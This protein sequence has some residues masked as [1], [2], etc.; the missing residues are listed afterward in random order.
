MAIGDKLVNLDALKAVH[1]ADAADVADLK[2]AVTG[3]TTA[4][5]SDAG[6]SLIAKTVSGGK[7]TEWEF[8]EAVTLDDTLT[9]AGEA[10]D[11]KAAGDALD[12]K[13]PVIIDSTSQSESH[14]GLAGVKSITFHGN[15]YAFSTAR[16]A[17]KKNLLPLVTKTW[18]ADSDRLSLQA[19]GHF[20]TYNG[21]PTAKGNSFVFDSALETPL[22]AGNYKVLVELSSTTA[23]NGTFYLSVFYESAPTTR[24][25]AVS[26]NI[27]SSR[28]NVF[29]FTATDKIVK[30]GYKTPY[31]K[32]EVYSNF[33]V[34]YGLYD[35]SATIVDTELT[36][37]SDGTQT[38][39]DTS[40]YDL[41][42]IDTMQHESV[43][44]Y[45]ADTKTYVDEHTPDII[46][47]WNDNIYALPEDFGAVG[48][49]TTDDTTALENCI[50]YSASS[51]KPVRGFRKYKAT[52]TLLINTRYQDVFLR[53]LVYTGNDAA[54]QLSERNI[55]FEF[56]VIES[57]GIGIL[58]QRYSTQACQYH[59]VTGNR[60]SSVGDC[61]K[62]TGNTY[63]ST[64]N[65]RQLASSAGNCINFD[66]SVI[67]GNISEYT[68]RDVTFSCPAGWAGKNLFG[69]KLYGCTVEGDVLNGYLNPINCSFFGCRHREFIDCIAKRLFD[70]DPT[71]TNGPLIKY[72]VNP[73]YHGS[74]GLKYITAD[75]IPWCSIDVSEIQNYTELPQ[76]ESND[77]DPNWLWLAYNG[78]DVGVA[79]R[80][81]ETGIYAN[82]AERVY[83]IG[84]H[85]VFEPGC[86]FIYTF[87]KATY[88]M[89]LFES[90]TDADIL[91]AYQQGGWGTDFVTGYSHTDYY[92]N[93][94]F[95][96]VGYSDLT[97]TQKDGN[98]ATL[99]DKLG[100]V[101]F[102]GTNEGNGVWHF[103]CKV[104]RSKHGRCSGYRENGWWCY[105]G[106]NETWEITKI[107]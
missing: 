70:N 10:A 29:D 9:Q 95:G 102:D 49:G 90:N 18:T 37:A 59:V 73:T 12:G 103:K 87:D 75:A 30:I 74:H 22:P 83:F 104:D 69:T 56:D 48:D 8:G 89:T 43:V 65:I 54:I 4:T 84:Y 107:G 72:T 93:A 44:A 76:H 91:A 62:V 106:T 82:Y 81:I 97:L 63:Y 98:T 100:N 19:I 105:D 99:Y 47:F 45:V 101:L 21:T 32:D 36:V 51:G 53:Y 94:S 92:M 27:G 38:Y 64:V 2:S 25:Q 34:W 3:M 52:S 1:D 31:A 67:T 11:A 24:V 55:K 80:G 78:Q 79:I 17:N 61:I 42:V 71:A 68:F 14:S 40:L 5:A 50:A 39:S 26:Q 41:S 86:R 7:V 77:G 35:T 20:V 16:Y 66:N 15:Q 6:K 28:I 96:A 57:S 13:A 60:I 58:F 85:K 46:G 88:D 33:V 23:T